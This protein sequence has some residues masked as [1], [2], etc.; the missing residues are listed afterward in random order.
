MEV[1]L[2]KYV[3]GAVALLVLAAG[4]WVTVYVDLEGLASR[5]FSIYSHSGAWYPSVKRLAE[6]VGYVNMLLVSLTPG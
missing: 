4:A 3:V 1:L 2:P 6:E 5:G